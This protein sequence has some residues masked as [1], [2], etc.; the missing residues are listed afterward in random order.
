[1][2]SPQMASLEDW[3]KA[4]N[5]LIDLSFKMTDIVSV[6]VNSSSPEGHLPMDFQS[7]FENLLSGT[8]N[9][10]DEETGM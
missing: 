3:S 1:M 2:E 10:I 9:G 8:L 7:D 4:V 5:E 6:V